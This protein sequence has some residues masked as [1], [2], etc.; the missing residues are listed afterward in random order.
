MPLIKSLTI[1]NCSLRL[2]HPSVGR[3]KSLKYMSIR[4]NRVC[5]LPM[6]FRF[7]QN[8]THFDL[9]LNLFRSLP[10][11]LFHLQSLKTITGFHDNLF[12]QNPSWNKEENLNIISIAPLKKTLLAKNNEGSTS[13]EVL[14]LKSFAIKNAVGVDIWSVPLPEQYRMEIASLKGNFDVCECCGKCVQ[15]ITD[16]QE[17]TG[18]Q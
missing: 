6:T 4:N 7:L 12:D 1:V 5:D 18:T 11:S 14:T 2:L 10:S 3:L 9:S 13:G 16:T 8:L 15:K 17:T